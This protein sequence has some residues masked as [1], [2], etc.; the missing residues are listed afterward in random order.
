MAS[1]WRHP[2]SRYW[3]A[4]FRDAHGRQRRLSTKETNRRRALKI[5][6][7]YEHSSRA[8]RSRRHVRRLIEHLQAELGGGEAICTLSLTTFAANWLA[9]KKPEVARRTFDFY[10]G[11]IAKFLRFL[12]P[13]ADLPLD[14]ITKATLLDYRN[15]LA[16]TLC[17]RST[18]HDL[19]AVKML[20][21]AAR[22]DGVITEN[23]AELIEAVRSRNSHAPRRAFSLP[24]LR[25]VAAV[26][27]PEWR[28]MILFGLYTG[29]RL[30]D[31]ASLT[32]ANVDL[33][34]AELRLITRKTGKRLLLPLAGPLL[35]HLEGIDSSDRSDVPL[36]PRAFK[37][38]ELRGLSGTLSNQFN[39]LLAQAGLRGHRNQSSSGKGRSS[40]RVASELSFH[41][42]RKTATTLLHE[43]GI[44]Q[45]VVMALIGHDSAE[46]HDIY[47][48]VG[49]EALCKAAAS[50][51]EL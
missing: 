30:S 51:P 19:C 15:A 33:E 36:H 9:T 5:A 37:S 8:L 25:A 28:S 48:A 43:A 34:K 23:P 17:A 12:G 38:L 14:Q 44:P 32:W 11:S 3:I 1:L 41:C 21:L 16:R 42:L 31:I 13:V 35:R 6:E 2:H 40:A 24:E 22:R 49:K 7:A 20:F 39:A 50:L 29:Q 18:N 47:V 46:V 26:A 10:S 27:D 45:A 4:C